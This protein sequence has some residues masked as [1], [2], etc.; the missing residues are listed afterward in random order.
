MR[1]EYIRIFLKI[2][3]NIRIRIQKFSY[4]RIIFGFGFVPKKRFD[5]LCCVCIG[6]YLVAPSAATPGDGKGAG[7]GAGVWAVLAAVLAAVI[8]VAALLGLALSDQQRLRQR[9]DTLEE[10]VLV[11][12]ELVQEVRHS[13]N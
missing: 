8:V 10:E 1:F 12:R 13:T 9:L 4:I 6:C 11:L 7:A 3:N 2:S 5:H